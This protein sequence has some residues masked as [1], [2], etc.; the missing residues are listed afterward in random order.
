MSY[1]DPIQRCNRH[2]IDRFL[3][4]FIQ[5][6]LV[7]WLRPEFARR[8]LD[9]WPN[10]F[11]QERS[12]IHL[13]HQLN[14]FAKRSSALQEVTQALHQQELIHNLHGELY[15]IT[16]NERSQALCQL[17]RSAAP[18]FGIRAFGQHLNGYVK[19]HGEIK[20][21]L[22]R[23]A[24]DRW[25]APGKL[26]NMVA[27]GLPINISLEDNLAKECAEE[28]TLS[29]E[30]AQQAQSVGAI[31]YCRES[32]EGL[33]QDLLYCYDLELPTDFTPH[34]SD[35]E[36]ESFQLYGLDEIADIVQN[37][38]E[39]KLNCNL[40]IIDFLIR[41]GYIKPDHPDYLTIINGLHHPFPKVSHPEA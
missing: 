2:Q 13:N 20:L 33:K 7:G 38:D 25:H 16:A 27:G 6:T 30:L 5:Q 23:R 31:S 40:V 39:F 10:W 8:L 4:F 29:R 17:D 36:T 14:T 15:P 32:K 35:G 41:V 11:Q 24:L 18:Y 22:G 12:G 28:A 34:G 26:D 21:W 1:L 9:Q 3:A 37:S 19:Q